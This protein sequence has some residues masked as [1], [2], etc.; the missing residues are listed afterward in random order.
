MA[1]APASPI[2][3]LKRLRVADTYE[4][5]VMRA[6]QTSKVRSSEHLLEGVQHRVGLEALADGCSARI[7]DLVAVEAEDV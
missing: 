5:N 6:T 1:A 2:L 3:L 4:S 7:A